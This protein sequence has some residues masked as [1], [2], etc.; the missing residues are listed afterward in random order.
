MLRDLFLAKSQ[1]G[2]A[3]ISIAIGQNYFLGDVKEKKLHCNCTSS[4]LLACYLLSGF[5]ALFLVLYTSSYCELIRAL[6]L[7]FFSFS[8]F[9]S[10]SSAATSHRVLYSRLAECGPASTT[11]YGSWRTCSPVESPKPS[12]GRCA[13]SRKKYIH[14]LSRNGLGCILRS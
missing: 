11:H 4:R 14:S 13:Q 10:I 5:P 12:G 8:L 6:S 3:G 1:R 9:L 2:P 7:F